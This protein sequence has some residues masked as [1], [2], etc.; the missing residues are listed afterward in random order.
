MDQGR[1]LLPQSKPQEI[2]ARACKISPQP[3]LWKLKCLNL[4]G[5]LVWASG[6]IPLDCLY[7]RPLQQHFH[8]LGLA[9]R[10]TPPRYSDHKSLLTYSENGKTC[11]FLPLES[12]SDFSRRSSRFLRMPLPRVGALR[13][14]ILRF[15]V[16]DQ[17]RPKAPHQHLE[18]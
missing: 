9:N 13:W 3:V 18:A 2:L 8:S 1:A 11:L 12:P 7:L 15:C 5:S 17:F 10:F 6:L 4:L 16:F 14:G